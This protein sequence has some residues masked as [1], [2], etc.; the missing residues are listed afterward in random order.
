MT[1]LPNP[2]VTQSTPQGI[3]NCRSGQGLALSS[4]RSYLGLGEVMYWPGSHKVKRSHKGVPHAPL[5]CRVVV[6]ER[7]DV[8]LEGD[9]VSLQSCP[10][11]P[12]GT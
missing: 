7:L 12:F 10:Q 11:D 5:V 8:A 3:N 9:G 4:L 2:K 1:L 6:Y